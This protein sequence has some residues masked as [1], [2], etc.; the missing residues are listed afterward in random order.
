MET[1]KD[2]K[3]SEFHVLLSG[4]KLPADLEK[5][6]ATGIQSVVSSALAGYPGPDDPGDDGPAGGGHQPHFGGGNGA[7]VVIP[8]KRWIGYWLKML[9]E[10]LTINPAEID[11][12]QRQLQQGLQR[13]MH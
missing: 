2:S 5:K 9:A 8:A 13:Q 1:S 3:G 4:L 12:Q 10:D 7:Y 6:I 11:V